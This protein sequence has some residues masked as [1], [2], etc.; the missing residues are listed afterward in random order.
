MGVS[1]MERIRRLLGGRADR[2]A[3]VSSALASAAR[4]QVGGLFPEPGPFDESPTETIE[5]APD[6][7]WELQD[8]GD[9]AREPKHR[10]Q[11]ED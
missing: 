6:L 11:R 7:P 1:G 3:T 2:R 4:L 10:S 9:S 5:L 8:D